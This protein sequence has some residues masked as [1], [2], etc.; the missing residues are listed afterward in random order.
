ME[1]RNGTVITTY[2]QVDY[3]PEYKWNNHGRSSFQQDQP[4][5]LGSVIEGEG[6]HP[7]CRW[8][9]TAIEQRRSLYFTVRNGSF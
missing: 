2:V 9:T 6:T 4:F 8:R 1:H 3:F 5:Q 7:T